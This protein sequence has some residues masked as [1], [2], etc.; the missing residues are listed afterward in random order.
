MRHQYTPIFRDLLTSSLWATSTP[1]TKCVWIVLLLDADPEGYVP[2]SIPGL[3]M[4]AGVTI[5]EVEIALEKLEGADAYSR[6]K[7]HEGRRVKAVDHGWFIHN[8]VSWRQRAVHES[9]KA[10][11]RN[12]A[13]SNRAKPANDNG[14]S[15]SDVDASS[16]SSETL[17]APLPLPK[18]KPS[19]PK[20]G[21]GKSAPRP[22]TL[23]DVLEH[24]SAATIP[25]VVHTLDEWRPTQQELDEL[26]ADAAIAGV[27]DF[28]ARLLELGNGP[29]G[30]QRGV[31]AHKVGAYVRAQFPKWKTWRE[32]DALKAQRA[33]EAPPSRRFGNEQAPPSQPARKPLPGLPAWV[34]EEH[35]DLAKS[36]G[37]NLKRAIAAYAKQAHIHPDTLKAQDV[38][39][40]FR[41]YLENLA[42]LAS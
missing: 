9:E 36:R 27:K 12:W 39:V 23:T 35:V 30:G 32:T 8:F 37:L 3:A 2:M 33:A 19:S 21:K 29:I 15:L 11:K 6:T 5:A 40:P 31:L 16:G 17:D 14:P 24:E 18:P 4:R 41:Q 25:A 7:A 22:V 28:D 1:A 34:Y 10:R 26:K 20:K 13:S 38:R 42:R